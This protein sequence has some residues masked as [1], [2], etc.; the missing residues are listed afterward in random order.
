LSTDE[1][2]NRIANDYDVSGQRIRQ[3]RKENLELIEQKAQEL[4]KYLPD[5]VETAKH[6]INISK[7]I[8]K[9]IANCKDHE[10]IDKLK[11]VKD[12]LQFKQLTNKLSA[13]ILRALGIFPAQ[14]PSLFIQNIYNDNRQQALITPEFQAF[15]NF[16][17]NNRQEIPDTE[18][19]WKE[20]ADSV[21]SQLKED[22]NH[23]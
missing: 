18:E 3:I 23:S 2:S 7:R 13:D 20:N 21:N 15:I 17:A 11:E 10:L 8:S 9:N 16:Q 14:S 22:I 12:I 6:D 4:L 5:I 1:S 19:E